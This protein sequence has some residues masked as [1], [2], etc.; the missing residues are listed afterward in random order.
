VAER[1][2]QARSL[3]LVQALLGSLVAETRL[4]DVEL[5]EVEGRERRVHSP[6]RQL[7]HA[8]GVPVR[9]EYPLLWE[10]SEGRCELVLR[11]LS[12]RPAAGAHPV[13]ERVA[14]RVGSAVEE[15][16][17]RHPRSSER[18]GEQPRGQGAG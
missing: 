15:W 8:D 5:L 6:S 3:E 18:A 9:L 13:A 17:R 1:I 10:T 2:R 16:L 11:V 4:L 12:E 7:S 14:N